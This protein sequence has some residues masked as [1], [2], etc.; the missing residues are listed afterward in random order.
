MLTA[1]SKILQSVCSELSFCSW[2]VVI[3]TLEV[4]GYPRLGVGR[5]KL[6]FKLEGAGQATDAR[7]HSYDLVAT[8]RT[9][10][11]S[12][13][14]TANATAHQSLRS[15]RTEQLFLKRATRYIANYSRHAIANDCSVPWLISPDQITHCQIDS[16]MSTMFT[17]C[18]HL[19]SSFWLFYQHN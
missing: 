9:S 10:C 16:K 11:L 7:V 2:I 18:F 12:G 5:L 14:A 4:T 8:R 15:W 6:D 3:C 19:N 13:L 1:V 17:I